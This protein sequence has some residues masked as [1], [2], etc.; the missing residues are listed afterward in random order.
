MLDTTDL[1]IWTDRA[2]TS[3][4]DNVIAI[5]K[6]LFVLQISTDLADVT[7]SLQ[8]IAVASEQIPRLYTPNKTEEPSTSDLMGKVQL[9][10]CM[11]PA[12]V[13]QTE[14]DFATETVLAGLVRHHDC[15]PTAKLGKSLTQVWENKT[16]PKL[17]DAVREVLETREAWQF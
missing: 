14:V 11:G 2:K 13:D 7:A 10:G 15:I 1:Q 16:L 6:A 9:T 12:S 4:Q 17:R 5:A 3:K 8:T